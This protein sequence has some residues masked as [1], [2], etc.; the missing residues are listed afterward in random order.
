[1]S[2]ISAIRSM[3]SG[4]THPSSPKYYGRRHPTK[5]GPNR[6]IGA[7]PMHPSKREAVTEGV[8]LRK[9]PKNIPSGVS[10]GIGVNGIRGASGGGRI[11]GEACVTLCKR[12]QRGK[13]PSLAARWVR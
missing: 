3:F 7:D 5:K 6:S 8:I 4:P 10:S 1:M 11:R 2:L 9:R 12:K 13:R